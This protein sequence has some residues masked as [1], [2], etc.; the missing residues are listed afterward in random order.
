MLIRYYSTCQKK[1][2]TSKHFRALAVSGV[3]ASFVTAL[4][5]NVHVVVTIILLSLLWTHQ[6]CG[7]NAKLLLLYGKRVTCRE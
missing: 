2:L 5:T 1:F 6:V 4:V 7:S 3:F